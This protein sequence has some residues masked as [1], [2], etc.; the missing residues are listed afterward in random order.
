MLEQVEQSGAGC[1]FQTP[2]EIAACI[3]V[4]TE[5]WEEFSKRAKEFASIHTWRETFRVYGELFQ[6]LV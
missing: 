3:E 6:S 2:N 4:V 1:C 5:N